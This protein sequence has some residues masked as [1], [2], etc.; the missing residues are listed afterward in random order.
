[1]ITHGNVGERFD[2]QK[3]SRDRQ[4]I[5]QVAVGRLAHQERSQ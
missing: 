4:G 5:G 2:E 3:S 1:M